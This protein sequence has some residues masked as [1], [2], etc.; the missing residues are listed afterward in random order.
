MSRMVKIGFMF[1][2]LPAPTNRVTI[3][4]KHRDQLGNYRPVLSYG[5][6]DYSLKGVEA[7]VKTVWPTITKYASV[8]DETVYPNPAPGGYQRVTY[9]GTGY[10]LM[11]SG[12]I[13]GTHRMGSS[14]KDSVTDRNM[15]AWDHP[16]LY[17]VGAG[18]QVTIGTANPTLT[19]A[20]LSLRAAD[21]MLRDLR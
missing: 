20:A 17:V 21:A 16:N 13:V 4:P 3:D 18:N 11:G 9:N 1:E 12:H 7:A 6:A 14:R 15:K 5:Y 8:Q 10:N 2:Q 19:A